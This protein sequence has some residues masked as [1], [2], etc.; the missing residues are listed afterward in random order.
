MWT[1]HTVTSEELSEIEPVWQAVGERLPNKF[2]APERFL[3]RIRTTSVIQRG[4]STSA[5]CWGANPC[6][7]NRDSARVSEK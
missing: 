4:A 5:R 6:S 7:D 2:S 3:F 1:I